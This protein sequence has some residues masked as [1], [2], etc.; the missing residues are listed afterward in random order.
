MQ[1]PG[2]DPLT[3]HAG[4]RPGTPAADVPRSV[5]VQPGTRRRTWQDGATGPHRI[6]PGHL[7]ARHPPARTN[8]VLPD[9]DRAA[10]RQCG[11]SRARPKTCQE[12][13]GNSR[14]PITRT[15]GDR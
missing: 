11:R 14:P 3:G 2:H 1:A 15:E 10:R 7:A 12:R 8:V 9:C 6:V 4:A 5:C 13:R